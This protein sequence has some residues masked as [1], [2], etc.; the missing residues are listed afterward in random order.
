MRRVFRGRLLPSPSSASLASSSHAPRPR[1]ADLFGHP[2]LIADTFYD[3]SSFYYDYGSRTHPALPLHRPRTRTP[4]A[5]SAHEARDP[6]I[7]P[8][9]PTPGWSS[10]GAT[11]RANRARLN[12][13]CPLDAWETDDGDRRGRGRR[14][15]RGDAGDEGDEGDDVSLREPGH[16]RRPHAFAIMAGPENSAR[17]AL[18]QLTCESSWG[19]RA[20]G[21]AAKQTRRL[22]LI[23]RSRKSPPASASS[24]RRRRGGRVFSAPS[25]PGDLRGRLDHRRTS[26]PRPPPPTRRGSNSAW[27]ARS[28]E[29][30]TTSFNGPACTRTAPSGSTSSTSASARTQFHEHAC[31]SSRRPRRR[32]GR[33]AGVVK[34]PGSSAP[35]T[36][37][38]AATRSIAA[39]ASLGRL[40]VE[41]LAPGLACASRAPRA[42]TT[43][44]RREAPPPPSTRSP[45]PRSFAWRDSSARA[46]RVRS[47]S[48]SRRSASAR[49]SSRARRSSLSFLRLKL[50]PRGSGSVRH[51]R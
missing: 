40:R 48:S 23:D 35:P 8:R 10:F 17:R 30:S 22:S 43:D 15:G 12:P 11:T 46:R 1:D 50:D 27:M 41:L 13:R 49:A 37:T 7:R 20:R 32:R 44:E 26:S 39:W 28:S 21:H 18:L 42:R 16:R 19:A 9:E 31:P 29:G 5:V 34:R 14:R 24:V 38:C 25:A 4:S 51:A 3:S 2:E 47:A 45:L 6:I 36:A 33:R